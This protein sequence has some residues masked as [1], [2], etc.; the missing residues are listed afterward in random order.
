MGDDRGIYIGL[1]HNPTD[2]EIA[3]AEAGLDAAL[4]T[5]L[6]C[7]DVPAALQDSFRPFHDLAVFVAYSV[8][9]SPAR[10][11][12]LLRLHD[13]KIAVLNAYTTKPHTVVS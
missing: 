11:A 7:N 4:L 2:A 8:P 10:T 1:R 3:T 9:K 6:Q 12:A 13:A 5:G